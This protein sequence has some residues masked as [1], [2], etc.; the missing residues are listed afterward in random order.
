M[1]S[2]GQVHAGHERSSGKKS[3][4]ILD[5]DHWL[6]QQKRASHFS[7]DILKHDCSPECLSKLTS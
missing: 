6:G 3:V 1:D 5:A 2:V 7:Q 4:I